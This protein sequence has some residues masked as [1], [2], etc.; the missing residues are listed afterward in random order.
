MCES[1]RFVKR[2]GRVYVVC[3][4]VP[5]HKQRQGMFT[6]TGAGASSSSSS[7]STWSSWSAWGWGEKGA[8]GV[9]AGRRSVFAGL[10][11]SGTSRFGSLLPRIARKI[12][13]ATL[14]LFPPR[15]N[16]SRTAVSLNPIAQSVSTACGDGNS[17]DAAAASASHP[18]Q[19]PPAA[20]AAAWQRPEHGTDRRARRRADH[21]RR[22]QRS[23]QR[24]PRA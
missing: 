5:K 13:V 9:A 7:S 18:H 17:V 19:R 11:L 21:L 20:P 23:P 2:K 3:D 12:S 1:C 16:A 6:T 22:P 24:S 15:C 4:K 8:A 14:R 10:T